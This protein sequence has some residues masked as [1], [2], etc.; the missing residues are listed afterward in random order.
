[1]SPTAADGDVPRSWKLIAE[2]R[3]VGS[4]ELTRPAA[5]STSLVPLWKTVSGK[6]VVEFVRAVNAR[7]HAEL[8]AAAQRMLD[9]LT[10][11][12][13][14]TARVSSFTMHPVGELRPMPEV[15]GLTEVASKLGVS[16]QRASQ[17]SKTRGFPPALTRI[18][19]GPIYSMAEVEIFAASRDQ[20]RSRFA[21]R[22]RPAARSHATGTVG[23]VG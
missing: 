21:D 4:S 3:P 17:I 15:A 13:G 23:D 14:G 11:N 8:V 5:E 10:V 12:L 7:D 6:E 2:F 16:R 22:G 18:A 1:M 19:S 9:E 20:R